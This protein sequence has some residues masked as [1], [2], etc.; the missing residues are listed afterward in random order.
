[1]AFRIKTLA[2]KNITTANTRIE[3]YAVPNDAL[4]TIFNNIR[5]LNDNTGGNLSQVNIY[6]VKGATEHRIWQR[7]KSVPYREV[8]VVKPEIFLEPG[9]IIQVEATVT[10]TYF[11]ASGMEKM[12]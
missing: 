5:V 6:L 4:G 3:L 2:A 1:M 11:V 12:S 7:N 8:R 10:D 9:D